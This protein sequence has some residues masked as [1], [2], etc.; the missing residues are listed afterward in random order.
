MA[1]QFWERGYFV[2]TVGDELTAEQTRKY[3]GYHKHEGINSKQLSL[4]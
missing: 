1:K 2:R 4:F 3:I